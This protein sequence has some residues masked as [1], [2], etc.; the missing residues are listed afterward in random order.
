[1]KHT[2]YTAADF[3]NEHCLQVKYKAKVYWKK[4]HKLRC[5]RASGLFQKS[6]TWADR[7]ILNNLP[8]I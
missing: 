4:D 3:Y 1:M 6:G 2:V 5:V 8:F 7:F